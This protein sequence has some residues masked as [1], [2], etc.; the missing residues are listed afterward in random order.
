MRRVVITG[1]GAV[2]ALGHEWP[3]ISAALREGRNRVRPIPEW[4]A[5]EGLN[6]R[7]GAPILDFETPASYP[8]KK[9]RSMG[10]VSVMAVNATERAL[11]QDRKS[12]RLNSSHVAISYAVFG[13]KTKKT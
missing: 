10:R 4:E 9:L 11:A 1:A 5:I 8:R 6:T 7:L 12:T 2:S 3:T 13:L